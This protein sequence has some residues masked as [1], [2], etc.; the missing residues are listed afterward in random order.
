[1]E[2]KEC[3]RRGSGGLGKAGGQR[4]PT[5]QAFK[6]H[7]H[8]HARHGDGLRLGVLAL[9]FG[10]DRREHREHAEARKD[11][12]DEAVVRVEQVRRVA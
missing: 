1:M 5:Y 11:I 12:C 6:L 3:P 10:L 2:G 8:R 4:G 9:A 7:L